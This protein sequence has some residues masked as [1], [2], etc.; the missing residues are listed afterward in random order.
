MFNEKYAAVSKIFKTLLEFLAETWNYIYLE[1]SFN[2][3]IGGSRGGTP[4]PPDVSQFIKSIDKKSMK[5]SK[6]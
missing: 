3:F 6:F 5:T 4:H 1:N 2:A